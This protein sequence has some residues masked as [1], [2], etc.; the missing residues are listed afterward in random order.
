LA[1]EIAVGAVA[2]SGGRLDAVQDLITPTLTGIC[3]RY[4]GV[5][6]PDE[7]RFAQLA[8]AMATYIFGDPTDN[9]TVRE[10]AL[11]AGDELRA[12]IDAAIA[13]ARRTPAGADV[14]VSRL[15]K[16]A[17]PDG[18][19]APDP[20][21]RAILSGMI[22]G[23][24]PASTMAGGNMLEMLLRR[25]DMMRQ[26]QA[27]ACADDD[28]LLQRCLWEAFRF[29]PLHP[30]PFRVCTEDAVIAVGAS[31][32]KQIKRGT[33]M[34]VGTHSAM[35]DPRRVANPTDFDPGRGPKDYMLF[36]YG[37][38]RCIG[39]PLARAQITQT[40]KPL[41]R[42]KNL[43]RASGPDGHLTKDG[44]F[45]AHLAVEFDAAQVD[46]AES[47]LWPTS[48]IGPTSPTPRISGGSPSI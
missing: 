14:I 15:L 2:A 24:V 19:P 33:K 13:Q 16:A 3:E 7:P 23:F 21:V 1:A 8:I 6:G 48:L 28:I 42:M 27:A 18:A 4:F 39:E 25:P 38:H 37:L 40:L 12:I 20:I 32:A 22:C 11:R 36:G 30:G 47:R 31:R 41:L 35:F 17:S 26:A 5:A 10:E 9:P 45:P 46:V 43:R 34:L 44:L 29:L